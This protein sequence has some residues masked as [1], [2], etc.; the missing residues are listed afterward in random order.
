MS[1]FQETMSTH[2]SASDVIELVRLRQKLTRS[3]KLVV[4][5]PNQVLFKI[6]FLT[7]N[8]KYRGF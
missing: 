8:L 6:P 7:D 3:G 5:Y 1:A 4:S 2:A